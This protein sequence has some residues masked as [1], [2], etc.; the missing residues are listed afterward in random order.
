[1][2]QNWYGGG[3]NSSDSRYLLYVSAVIFLLWL[4]VFLAYY[5]GLFT[6][7]VMAQIPQRIQGYNTHHPL[8]HTLYLQFFY[9]IVGERLFASYNGG[10][11]AAT[12][13]QMIAFSLML[14]FSH[15]Y[16]RRIG[17]RRRWRFLLI[18]LTGIL[19]VFSM[20]SISLTKDTLFAGFFG[21]Q[22]TLLC[23]CW[24]L[25]DLTVGN[26]RYCALYIF[27]TIGVILLR[28]NGAYS[29][30]AL[31]IFLIVRY[32][33]SNHK[34]DRVLIYTLS[35]LAVGIILSVVLELGL[36]ANAGSQNEMLSLPY[37][38]LACAYTDKRDSMSQEE[39][40]DIITILP[41]VEKYNSH[42]ADE[43]KGTATGPENIIRLVSTYW[44]I[45]IKYPLSYLKGFFLLDAG[46]LSLTDV[47]FAGMYAN[48]NR[49]GIF[50]SNTRPG[51]EVIHRTL[52][53]LL[54]SFYEKLYTSNAYEYVLGLNL[55]CSPALYFWIICSLLLYALVYRFMGAL[56]LFIFLEAYI[57]TVL[58]GPCVLPRYA[59]PYIVCIPQLAV[60]FMG[61]GK[62]TAKNM[63]I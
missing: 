27:S 40:E 23:Y 56:P 12:I 24:T 46:Y 39:K 15:L 17:L 26:K 51:F 54:E 32:K 28:N 61:V 57:L 22:F 63:H 3:V 53:P 33:V 16:L 19:P 13:V 7:D 5:P 34:E 48:E 60:S 25:P 29:V 50:L 8:L 45:G 62:E 55:L 42:C 35:G 2:V 49:A 44:R 59:L 21:M 10:I 52:F 41:D 36:Q 58:A 1:M 30:L 37:Q 31:V 43:I 38:Q 11:A 47:S 20:L 9:F 6:Y 14:S 4:P 18:A